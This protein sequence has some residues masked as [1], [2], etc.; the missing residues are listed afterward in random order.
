MIL[1][2]KIVRKF[3]KSLKR[4]TDEELNC[5]IKKYNAKPSL[6]SE[7]SYKYFIKSNWAKQ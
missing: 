3:Q 7:E 6:L 5:L 1:P 2:S 4:K